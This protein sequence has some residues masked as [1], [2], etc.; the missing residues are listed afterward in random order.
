VRLRT[1]NSSCSGE[2]EAASWAVMR[3]SDTQAWMVAS[4]D[5]S[6]SSIGRMPWFDREEEARDRPPPPPPL[7]PPPTLC[8]R[9]RAMK[10]CC[11]GER[12][13]GAAEA[14]ALLLVAR[15]GGGE[16]L[17]GRRGL[18]LRPRVGP[19]GRGEALASWRQRCR[20]ACCSGV[21]PAMEGSGALL[22]AAAG[23]AGARL[24]GRRGAELRPRLGAAG[25]GDWLDWRRLS[26]NACCSGDKPCMLGVA[27]LA[28]GAGGGEPVLL[29][30]SK[31]A[32]CSGERPRGAP[33]LL[34]PP[35]GAGVRL[36]GLRGA[37]LRPR[38]GA[39]G[40]GE[41]LVSMRLRC[42]KAC[43]SGVSPGMEEATPLLATDGGA[44]AGGGGG[45]AALRP[46]L[47]A[48][49]RPRE[50]A[51]GAGEELSCLLRSRKACCSGD[52]LLWVLLAGG[53]APPGC[54]APADWDR[55]RFRNCSCSG[56]Y[57]AAS[58]L[59]MVPLTTWAC[60]AQTGE[61]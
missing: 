9:L 13:E 56:E 19:E 39:A 40:G 24:L 50:G 17:A 51:A 42:R 54:R 7:L 49:L 25:A 30:R 10:A 48:V 59:L 18:E 6:S 22:A 44:A 21:S 36:L 57:L 46:R 61:R 26:K 60:K 28:A 4:R 58:S 41:V 45:A 1:R 15:W 43:C 37:G 35:A 20:K 55:L 38:L 16:R 14:A 32:C 12:L 3:P 27:L 31:N 8:A 33:P 52:R 11:S 53:A 34:P 29:L 5:A 23:A 2:H 47:G